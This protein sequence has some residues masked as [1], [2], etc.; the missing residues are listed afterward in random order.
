[1]VGEDTAKMFVWSTGADSPRPVHLV[2]NNRGVWKAK[3]WN[4]LSVGVRAPV[5]VVDDDL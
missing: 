2:K 1:M 5:Q 3:N 4:S